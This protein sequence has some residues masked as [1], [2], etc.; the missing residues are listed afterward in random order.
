MDTLGSFDPDAFAAALVRV[1]G[2]ESLATLPAATQGVFLS[3]PTD[4]S[5]ARWSHTFQ[6]CVI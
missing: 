2:E 1:D 6:V 4:L 5:L 3:H